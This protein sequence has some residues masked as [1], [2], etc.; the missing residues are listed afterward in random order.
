MAGLR[1]SAVSAGFWAVAGLA[2][3]FLCSLAIGG[4]IGLI[5][6]SAAFDRALPESVLQNINLI[7]TTVG[8]AFLFGKWLAR[9]VSYRELPVY[10][11][12]PIPPHLVIWLIVTIWIEPP[13]YRYSFW[14][15]GMLAAAISPIFTLAGIKRGRALARRT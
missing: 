5:T 9:N 15:V 1:R 7:L 10:V 12:A 3:Q 2:G 4:V 8:V 11:I 13:A 14:I 6:L